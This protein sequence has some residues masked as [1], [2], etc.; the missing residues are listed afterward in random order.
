[1]FTKFLTPLEAREIDMRFPKNEVDINFFGGYEGAERTIA[2]FGEISDGYPLTTLKIRLKGKASL[3]HRDYLG[4]VLSLG[5]KRELIGDIIP[6]DDGAILF[7]L[8]EIADFITDNLTK[9]ANTGVAVST[10][11]EDDICQIKRNY[12]KISQTVSSLRLDAVVASAVS[13]SRGV[14]SELISKGHVMHNYKEASSSSAP[15]KDG[16]IITVRGYGKFL[17][18]TDERLT[19]KGRIH[20]DINKFA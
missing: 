20:I 1:M 2:S 15:V 16:D 5:I 7:C 14:S 17:I 8:E 19:R 12:I 11:S 10:A 4:S 3:S 6:S 13:K 18:N 9:I